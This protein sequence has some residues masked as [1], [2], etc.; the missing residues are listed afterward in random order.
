MTAGT[1]SVSASADGAMHLEIYPMPNPMNE[2][3]VESIELEQVG[4]ELAILWPTFKTLYSEFKKSAKQV[5]IANVTN[6]GATTRAAWRE[7][8]LIQG[9][10]PIAVGT[11]DSTSLLRGSGSN[12]AAFAMQPVWMFG[13]TEITHLAEMA[14]EGQERGVVSITKDEV[15]RSLEQFMNGINAFCEG[16]GSGAFDQIPT[17]ATITTGGSG[18]QTSIIAGINAAARFTDQQVVQIFPSEGGTS[19]GTATISF[20][21]AVTQTLFFSTA[22]PSTG[23]A[24][25]V[26]DY[27][28]PLG[29][30][31]ATGTSV[32]GLQYWNRNGN[33]ATFAGV[34]SANYPGRLSCPTI[35]LSGSPIT[36]SVAQRSLVLLTRAMG[37]K[38]KEL[39]GG[40][41]Y[42]T[43]DQMYTIDSQF[44]SSLITQ[45]L[46]AG[47]AV[48][49]KS[50][51]DFSDRFGGKKFL[52]SAT[53][54]PARADLI[55][56]ENWA[57]GELKEP[58]LYDF[59]G[60]NTIMPVPDVGTT[61]GTYLTN[62]MFVYEAGFQLCN[63]ANRHGLFIQQAGQLVA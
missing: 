23:G 2:A 19:R 27:I 25:A 43:P 35:N 51:K 3:A 63:R 48:P 55:F 5:N 13:V 44:Y 57:F 22:L 56:P 60:G 15:K 38:A 34:P 53:A 18:A 37:D 21:D 24:T 46:E 6:G 28:M 58:G 14:T 59:G 11:G 39:G 9:G 7:S 52:T 33:T 12:T 41:W 54:S 30:S 10:A 45:N 61:N 50:R 36:P 4:K 40:F 31:G 20:V 47:D 16:D 49:E 42:G 32:L 1:R 29:A 8:M 26:G 17:T 62:K